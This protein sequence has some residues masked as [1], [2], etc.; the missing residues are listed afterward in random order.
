MYNFLAESLIQ[1][2]LSDSGYLI[3]RIFLN[4]DRHFF[5]EG[6]S[7]LS[8][9]FRDTERSQWNPQICSLVVQMSFAYV[10][11]FD[12]YIPPFELQDE[13]TVNQ[14]HYMGETLK[15]QTGKRLGFKMKSDDAENA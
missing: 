8:S 5:V 13:I 14:M 6:R 2:R 7:Q 15:L 1:N 12:L 10:L 3:S 4:N 9:L 11:S